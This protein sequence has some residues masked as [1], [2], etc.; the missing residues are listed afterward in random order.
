MAVN[1]IIYEY[2]GVVMTTKKYV[3]SIAVVL[4]SSFPLLLA[5]MG[6]PAHAQSD[7]LPQFNL[8][9]TPVSPAFTL[10]GIAPTTVERPN[11]PAAIA[12]SLLSSTSGLTQLPTD[13]ALEI[14]PYWLFGHPTLTWQS[15]TTRTVL[16]SVERTATFSIGTA[17]SDSA[18]SASTSTSLAVGFRT[19]LFSGTMSARSQRY[20]DTVQQQLTQNAANF[21]A[22]TATARKQADDRFIAQLKANEGNSAAQE[23][24]RQEHETALNKI[25]QQAIA[26]FEQGELQDIALER[27]G[28]LLELALGGTWQFANAIADSGRFAR[29]GAWITP[30]YQW[31]HW[32]VVGVGRIFADKVG[33]ST[34]VTIDAGARLIYT[35]SQFGISLEAA[36]QTFTWTSA[37]ENEWRLAAVADVE[38][39]DGT[40]VTMT[41]GRDFHGSR[42]GSFLAKLGLAF[43]LGSQRYVVEK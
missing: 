6:S 33:D 35:A 39:R 5:V 38:I 36:G 13:Y 43:H 18:S 29:F 30:A 17:R 7:T 20:L 11:T 25:N 28:F 14:S 31:Q 27:E 23:V 15:D 26:Q 34:Q 22:A 8:L 37:P 3:R 32:S 41:F 42:T 12:V 4:C 40:W 1:T 21:Y 24:A 2:K 16:E 10:L 19:S 9:R